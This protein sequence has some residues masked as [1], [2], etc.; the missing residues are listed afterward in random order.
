MRPGEDYPVVSP[1]AEVKERARDGKRLKRLNLQPQ[2]VVFV[3]FCGVG[4]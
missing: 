2:A 4:D 1:M 3:Y